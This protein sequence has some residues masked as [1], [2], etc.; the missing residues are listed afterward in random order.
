MIDRTV[1][2]AK[3]TTLVLTIALFASSLPH[4]RAQFS[5]QP[6]V[7]VAPSA[8]PAP[9]AEVVYAFDLGRAVV[10]HQDDASSVYSVAATQDLRS[11]STGGKVRLLVVEKGAGGSMSHLLTINTGK[12]KTVAQL[13]TFLAEVFRRYL[14]VPAA[15]QELG[16]VGDLAH[17]GEMHFIAE[18]T[19]VFRYDWLTPGEP[20][21][22]TRLKRND[23]QVFLGILTHLK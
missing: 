17:G 22:S 21:H 16:K 20:L 19:D 1:P 10:D 9:A 11:K 2:R 3:H 8:A 4:V 23:I 5:S 6:A 13:T 12:Y 14:A 7:P 15:N 18:S